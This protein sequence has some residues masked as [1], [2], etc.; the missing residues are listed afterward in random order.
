M[1]AVHRSLRLQNLPRLRSV[2]HTL[3][4][5]R[6]PAGI[7]QFNRALSTSNTSSD[8]PAASFSSLFGIPG[9]TALSLQ[10]PFKEAQGSLFMD[11]ISRILDTDRTVK[12]TAKGKEPTM[13]A[14]VVS[15]NGRGSA[16]F[17]IGKGETAEDALE[18]ARRKSLD[19]TKWVTIP[20]SPDGRLYMDSIGKWK[21]TKVLMRRVKE[22]KQGR[23]CGRLV[24]GIC[25]TF[26]IKHITAKRITRKR[27]PYTFCSVSLS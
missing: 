18:D 14:L 19:T 26:G 3:Q 12:V 27:S 2:A 22:T 13:R 23:T 11:P 6:L 7:S 9:T 8:K 17:G 25:E 21:G 15:G 24:Y 20:I 16:G 1:K 4:K 10:N 5:H